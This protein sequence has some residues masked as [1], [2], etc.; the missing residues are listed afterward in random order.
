MRRFGLFLVLATFISASLLNWGHFKPL[1]SDGD[2]PTGSGSRHVPTLHEGY[3]AVAKDYPGFAGVYVDGDELIILFRG[4]PSASVDQVQGS[5]AERLGDQS[6][7]ELRPAYRQVRYDFVQLSEWYSS[8]FSEST[9]IP[10]LV[11]AGIDEINGTVVLGVT[12]VS[13]AE[14]IAVQQAKKH[15]VPADALSLVRRARP[16]WHAAC[17]VEPPSGTLSDCYRPIVGGIEVRASD[18]ITGGPLEH[19]KCTLGFIAVKLNLTRGFVTNAHCTKTPGIV[20]GIG[21]PFGQQYASEYAG[22]ETQDP[23]FFQGGAGDPYCTDPSALCRYSDAAF[24]TKSSDVTDQLGRIAWAQQGSTT[25]NGTSKF[26]ITGT[27]GIVSGQTL[28]L[29]GITSGNASGTVLQ[30]PNNCVT[31]YHGF[32]S[33]AHHWLVCQAVLGLTTADGDSGS[34]VFALGQN[35]AVTLKGI[36]WGGS[37]GVT[38]VS[39]IG[40]VTRWTDLGPLYVCVTSC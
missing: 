33:G 32:Y 4:D 26:Q 24:I 1:A 36:A 15:G 31:I 13:A 17:V 20:D 27:A 12:D 40:G 19:G 39:A 38:F 16:S 34:P 30:A 21:T 35:G 18:P 9:L 25:W 23:A 8:M 29:V 28:R 11:S 10:G 3:A 14:S 37:P 7:R 2:V 6:L 22:R 5:V